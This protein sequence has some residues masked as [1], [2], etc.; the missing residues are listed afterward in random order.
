MAGYSCFFFLLVVPCHLAFAETPEGLKGHLTAKKILAEASAMIPDIPDEEIDSNFKWAQKNKV[1]S[2]GR[3]AEIQGKLGDQRG[4]RETANRAIRVAGGQ[5][6][7][8][9]ELFVV[10]SAQVYNGFLEDGKRTLEAGL[11]AALSIEKKRRDVHLLNFVAPLTKVGDVPKAIK[12]ANLIQSQSWRTN[13]LIKIGYVLIEDKKYA[14][15][16]KIY[17]RAYHMV[18]SIEK[19]NSRAQMLQFIASGKSKLNHLSEATKILEEAWQVGNTVQNIETKISTLSYIADEQDRFGHAKRA[20]E[21]LAQVI[22]FA[23][24]EKETDKKFDAYLTIGLHQLDSKHHSRALPLIE[25]ALEIARTMDSPAKKAFAFRSIANAYHSLGNEGKAKDLFLMAV[26]YLKSADSERN[27]VF[28]LGSFAQDMVR[29]G[30]WK[31]SELIPVEKAFEKIVPQKQEPALVS[32]ALS[33]LATLQATAGQFPKA[34]ATANRIQSEQVLHGWA[35][36][37]IG[38]AWVRFGETKAAWEWARGLKS[39]WSHI[40][41]LIGVVSGMVN[42]TNKG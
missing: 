23:Q 1:S 37:G 22:A 12:I 30:P 8:A 24:A 15:A 4:L 28:T 10:V 29:M 7:L 40:Q 5:S 20:K 27:R 35:M 42:A 13:A 34:I 32:Y 31:T 14:K 39:P 25:R 17:D 16:A 19:P 6:H 33:Q 26:E 38:E 3:I 18:A 36:R 2:L 21:M 9:Y 41:G 11:A